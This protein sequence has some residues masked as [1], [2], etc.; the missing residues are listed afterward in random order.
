MHGP[1]RTYDELAATVDHVVKQLTQQGIKRNAA[2]FIVAKRYK[3]EQWH[4][5]RLV[6]SARKRERECLSGSSSS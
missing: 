1:P 5:A 4:I 6:K 3:L 2:Y